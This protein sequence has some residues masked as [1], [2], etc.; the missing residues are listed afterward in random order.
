MNKYRDKF[1]RDKIDILKQHGFLYE[2][3]R[4]VKGD[5]E[6][7]C[8]VVSKLSITLLFKMIENSDKKYC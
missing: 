8:L 1:Y 6:L 7:D 2:G 3:D 5:L 4:F